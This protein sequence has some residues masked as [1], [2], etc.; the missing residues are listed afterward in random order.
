MNHA[1]YFELIKK[2]SKQNWKPFINGGYGAGPSYLQDLSV[3]TD[4]ENA[5]KNL[6]VKEHYARAT[7][8]DDLN[9]WFAWGYGCNSDF[10]ESWTEIFPDRSASSSYIDFFY[11]CSLVHRELY[12]T[13]DGGRCSIP[14]PEKTFDS[15]T[16]KVLSYWI[17]SERL[18][19]YRI[20]NELEGCKDLDSYVQRANIKVETLPWMS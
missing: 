19:F 5:F 6:E 10:H 12:V 4:G 14:L 8:M 18:E 15:N 16:N 17:S 7:C 3:W 1:A 11:G 2:T 13:V 20:L 9:M